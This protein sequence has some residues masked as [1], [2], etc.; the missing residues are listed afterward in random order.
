MEYGA[1]NK[2]WRNEIIVIFFKKNCW[3]A[4]KFW[5]AAMQW[6]AKYQYLEFSLIH[7]TYHVFKKATEDSKNEHLET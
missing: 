7:P 1:L 3:V 6:H 5:G 2:I 4:H